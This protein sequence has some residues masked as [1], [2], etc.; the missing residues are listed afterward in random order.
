[1][2]G[3]TDS[4][5]LAIFRDLFLYGDEA[6]PDDAA[7]G[8]VAGWDSM[9]HL[10]LVAELEASFRVRFTTAEILDMTTVG[11]IRR[12]LAGKG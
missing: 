3:E 2:N 4:K 12:V 11:A 6:L 10:A 7:M 5:I 1:M 9:Q 8:T